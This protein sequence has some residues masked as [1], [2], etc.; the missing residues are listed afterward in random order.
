MKQELA[1]I[2]DF[3]VFL[4][5][6]I[7]FSYNNPLTLFLSFFYPLFVYFF[8][9]VF[10]I[11]N[12]LFVYFFPTFSVFFTHLLILGDIFVY[13]LRPSVALFV[14]VGVMVPSPS[15]AEQEGAGVGGGVGGGYGGGG[16]V[17]L[18]FRHQNRSNR[19]EGCNQEEGG[20]GFGVRCVRHFCRR[21]K[22]GID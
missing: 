22:T 20:G 18:R 17:G 16:G 10:S 21:E 15:P 3:K 2:W 9:H 19:K 1:E 8:I 11:F 4:K 13:D 5:E 6:T 14:V 12:P 7:Y